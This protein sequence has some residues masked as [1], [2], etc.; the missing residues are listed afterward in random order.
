MYFLGALLVGNG[1]I[2]FISFFKA[3]SDNKKKEEEA[4]N[5]RPIDVEPSKVI[6]VEVVESEVVDK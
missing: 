2:D 1:L 6:D 4:I 5:S 3:I